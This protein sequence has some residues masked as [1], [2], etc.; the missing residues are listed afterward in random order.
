MKNMKEK[1]SDF[2]CK[3]WFLVVGFF[4]LGV[5]LL[6][7]GKI[8]FD[9]GNRANK[10]PET[11]G[12][13]EKL[14]T[15]S[16]SYSGYRINPRQIFG[17]GVY[18]QYTVNGK[19]Y[20]SSRMKSFGKYESTDFSKIEKL[21]DV[22]ITKKAIVVYLN[23]KDPKVNVIFRG[24]PNYYLVYF[25]GGITSSLISMISIVFYFVAKIKE[26]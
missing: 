25:T 14:K 3:Y 18:Y 23:P 13:I 2:G 11:L 8:L 9:N 5:F 20:S 26:E 6:Y 12:K 1:T 10:W 22:L 19:T 21:R 17:L 15:Y 24:K 7:Y 4:L 16:Y